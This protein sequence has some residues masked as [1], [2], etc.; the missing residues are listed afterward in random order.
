VSVVVSNESGVGVDEAELSR[1]ALFVLEEM[2][3]NPDAELSLMLV[4]EP[5]MSRLHEQYMGEPGPTDVLAFPMDDLEGESAEGAESELVGD[6][7]LCPT[8][9][10]AQAHD[11]GHDVAS[12]LRLLCV[13]GVLH[14]LGYDHHE[15]EEEREMFGTQSRL[16]GAFTSVSA[17]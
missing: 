4:D 2:S 11:A 1:L 3:V 12:E 10:E 14:L 7:V 15:P 5:T 13:H 16:L 8:I 9:A 17:S 6:V